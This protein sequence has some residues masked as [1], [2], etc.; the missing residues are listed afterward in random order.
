M[1]RVSLP[2][3]LTCSDCIIRLERQ[4]LEWGENYRF[5]SCADVDIVSPNV[6][7]DIPF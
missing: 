3:D 4:A 7:Y 5:R 6:T 2:S 1:Y